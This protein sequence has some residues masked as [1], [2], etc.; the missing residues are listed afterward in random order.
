VPVRN[1]HGRVVA[2]MN[3]GV[4]AA[5]VSVD[6]MIHRFLPVLEENSLDLSHLLE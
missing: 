5:R 3:I 1:R 2:A 6:E 4:H